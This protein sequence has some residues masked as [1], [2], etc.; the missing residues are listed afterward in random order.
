MFDIVLIFDVMVLCWS[1]PLWQR[2]RYWDVR[3]ALCNCF[4]VLICGG[5][6]ER[7]SQLYKH[8]WT[9]H[10]FAWCAH[11]PCMRYTPRV[12]WPSCPCMWSEFT[13]LSWHG[14]L[15]PCA[16]T[17]KKKCQPQLQIS[18]D[19]CSGNWTLG[20]FE[21]KRANHSRYNLRV[22]AP[23][24]APN[25]HPNKMGT[26]KVVFG[27]MLLNRLKLACFGELSNSVMFLAGTFLE[28]SDRVHSLESSLLFLLSG[29][30][31]RF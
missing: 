7:S 31:E 13:W 4:E 8:M 15:T 17:S 18:V 25:R 24:I 28:L 22:L 30:A 6:G 29:S 20:W 23:A 14:L 12:Y 3:F 26:S 1:S 5:A 11:T 27:R 9:A 19:K 2:A 10:V 21:R 16:K